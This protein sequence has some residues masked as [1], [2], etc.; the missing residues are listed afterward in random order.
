L[1]ETPV[2]DLKGLNCPLPVLKTRKRLSKMR[3]GA[4]LRVETTDPLAGLDIPAFCNDSGHEL[5]EMS[6]TE[7]G[8]VFL[9]RRRPA[10][11]RKTA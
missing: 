9:I 1:A 7:A 8:H 11:T 4:L 2:Y 10:R 5:V 3:P 6:A